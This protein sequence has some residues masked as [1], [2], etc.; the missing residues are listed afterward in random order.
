MHESHSVTAL[1]QNVQQQ[2]KE[3]KTAILFWLKKYWIYNTF[4]QYYI[5]YWPSLCGH[6]VW[7]KEQQWY[8]NPND[9][10]THSEKLL[11][12][13]T[14]LPLIRFSFKRLQKRNQSTCITFK[15]FMF[16]KCNVQGC[17]GSHHHIRKKAWIITKTN[18]IKFLILCKTFPSDSLMDKKSLKSFHL[19][20]RKI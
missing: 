17:S 5:H 4:N 14:L 8:D 1:T 7:I 10:Y 15:I 19:I 6:N 20:G 16:L 3:D 11:K 12:K 18:K 2:I 13:K 9:L